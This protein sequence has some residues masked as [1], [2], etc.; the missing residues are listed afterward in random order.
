MSTPFNLRTTSN[1]LVRRAGRALGRLNDRHPW[2]H[3]AHF[4]PWIL[5]HLPSSPQ[6]ALD[7]GCGRGGLVAALRGRVAQVDG[8][9]PDEQMARAASERFR[10]IPR[11]RIMQRTLEEL[12]PA[13]GGYDAITMVAS[14]HHMDLEDSLLQVRSLLRPGGRFLAATL[15]DPTGAADLAWDIGNALSNPVIGMIRHPRPA[16]PTGEPAPYLPVQDSTWGTAELRSRA[17]AILPGVRVRRRVG[18]RAT[19]FWE[20]PGGAVLRAGE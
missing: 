4:H 6:R 14:L 10:A 19:I 18:F 12:D 5:R 1:P 3:N 2:D 7:V 13:E 9:D 11:V 8:I 20:A 15:I 17:S 16:S